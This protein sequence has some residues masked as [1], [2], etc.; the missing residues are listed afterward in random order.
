MGQ[1]EIIMGKIKLAEMNAC[2]SKP[3]VF[4][5]LFSFLLFTKTDAVNRKG[6]VTPLFL[7]YPVPLS[8][9]KR[10]Y[11]CWENQSLMLKI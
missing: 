11:F 9:P 1:I 10:C 7:I 3:L 2:G 8:S 5:L 6:K 4:L